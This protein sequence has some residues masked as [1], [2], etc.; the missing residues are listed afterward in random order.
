M[1]FCQLTKLI[2]T[3]I[4]LLFSTVTYA[5]E[6]NEIIVFTG[7]E[8]SDGVTQNDFDMQMLSAIELQTKTKV[9]EKMIAYL[10]SE[11]LKGSKFD[12]IASSVYVNVQGVKL[13]V[14]KLKIESTNQ[15]HIYGIRG[16]E[17]LRV[18]CVRKTSESIPLSYGKCGD[19]VKKVYGVDISKGSN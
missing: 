10:S 6:N 18:A 19:A 3:F 12:V 7:S 1:K 17:L 8:N 4:F 11:G 2:N 9:K 14:V 5:V 16:A 15:V 13:A